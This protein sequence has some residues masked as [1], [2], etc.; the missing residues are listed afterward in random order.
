MTTAKHIIHIDMDAFF[1][2]IEQR[3]NPQ[4]RG[5]PVVVGADPKKGKG[6][7]VV[8][9]C[10]YEARKFGIH[11]A[12]P[13]SIAYR[14]CP[15]AVFLP[16][17]MEEYIKVSHQMFEIFN[18]FSPKIEQ[19]SIDEA[20]LD[21][22]GS[23]HLFGTPRQ[24][25]LLLKKQIK[26]EIRLT[27]SVGLAPNKFIAKIASDLEKPDGLVQVE[28]ENIKGFLW[29]LDIGRMWGVGEKTL[30]ILHELNIK[31]FGD[32]AA[33]SMQEVRALFGKNGEHF[34]QLAHGIDNREVE[35]EEEI[36]SISNEITF[37]QD[38]ADQTMIKGTL[39]SLS[40]KVSGRL[41]KEGLKGKTITMKIRLENFKTFTRAVTI[42]SLTNYADVIYDAISNLYNNFQSGGKKIRLVGVRVSN[43]ISDEFEFDSGENIQRENLH[44]A[45]EKIRDKFGD[46]I[47]HRAGS[48]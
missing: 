12:M 15:K 18:E 3:N 19:I 26:K 38:T 8:S 13:I 29:P 14:K 28:Q 34:W 11:S 48:K 6:R 40:E 43:F 22:T 10:S 36:K 32:L 20:F 9:T 42:G 39:L 31:T 23:Y 30:G 17:N 47:I 5:K 7:G 44:K 33:K 2:A 41:R 24:T 46:E 25:C 37:E 1:A 45:V 21:I 4:Y 35:I 27:S 16:V